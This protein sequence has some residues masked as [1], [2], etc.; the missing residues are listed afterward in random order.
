M[1]FKL[2]NNTG[3][4]TDY[5]D[6]DAIET[7]TTTKEFVKWHEGRNLKPSFTVYDGAGRIVRQVR[8]GKDLE[9]KATSGGPTTGDVARAGAAL[10]ERVDELGSQ[11]GEHEN[12]LISLGKTIATLSSQHDSMA[13]QV[14]SL[15]S[16]LAALKAAKTSQS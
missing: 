16:E 7:A 6:A 11:V 15:Q 14:S 10:E 9:V 1:S 12:A 4:A 2:V 5:D 3:A 8:E 13:S